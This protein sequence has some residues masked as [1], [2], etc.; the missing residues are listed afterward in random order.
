MYSSA[1]KPLSSGLGFWLKSPTL[2]FHFPAAPASI[3]VPKPFSPLWL[4][5]WSTDP[6]CLASSICHF[7]PTV[8]WQAWP[9]QIAKQN[10]VSPNHKERKMRICYMPPAV[11]QQEKGECWNKSSSCKWSEK[12][13]FAGAAL[14]QRSIET[15][16][17]SDWTEGKKE[18]F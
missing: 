6:H 5:Y 9:G 14:W 1:H 4:C 2:G 11:P 15:S 3:W 10:M 7:T 12:G 13:C 17:I 18:T 16:S 8:L